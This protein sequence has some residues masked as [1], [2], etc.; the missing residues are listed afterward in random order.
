MRAILSNDF[1]DF[2]GISL[3]FLLFCGELVQTGCFK[4]TDEANFSEVTDMVSFS[5]AINRNITNYFN[6]FVLNAI[7]F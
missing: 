3:E 1:Y 5:R 7:Y 2:Y 4:K 6:L